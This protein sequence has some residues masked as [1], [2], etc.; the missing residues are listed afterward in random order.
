VHLDG[1]EPDGATMARAVKSLLEPVWL[2]DESMPRFAHE[3]LERLVTTT[4]AAT[5]TISINR[6]DGRGLVSLA[7]IHPELTFEGERFPLPVGRPWSGELWLAGPQQPHHRVLAQLAAERFG[8]ALENERLRD[9]DL[10]R[11]TWLT[12]LAE[13]S[14]LLAQSLDIDLTMALIPRVVVPRLGQWCAIYTARDASEL[15]LAAIAH[16]DETAVPALMT[17][18]ENA[19]PETLQRSDTYSQLTGPLDGF[20]V[21]LIARGQR[22]GVLAIGRL[23]AGRRDPDEIAVAEDIARRAALALDNARTHDE[24]RRVAQALQ[25]A[26]L[27]P[28]LPTVPD[29]GLGA[30]YVPAAEGVD[31]GGDFYDVIKMPDGRTLLLVGDVS[32]K[33]VQAATVTGLVRDVLRVLVRDGRSVPSILATLNDTLFERRERHCTLALAAV[34]P[35][36]DNGAVSVSIYLAG[37]EAPLLLRASG[38]CAPA[39]K[40][41]T[42]LGLLPKVTC[43]ETQVVLDRG[44]TLVFF[45]D[46]VTDRRK[47]DTFY[48]MEG[49]RRATARLAG[50]P[51][52]VIAAQLRLAALD[53][54]AEPARDDLCLVVL[55]NDTEHPS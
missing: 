26:L 41:G 15:K 51:A 39:G 8:L 31:V 30:E 6:A 47:G 46:G 28:V 54:S 14:E 19:G 38:E 5:A 34:S 27:P 24:R 33:G 9:T 35:P 10:R 42:A 16:A 21:P 3:L 45:T 48:G 50:Y 7:T 36:G 29:L 40:W 23:P 25:K 43:P 22:L 18:L 4:N 44:D 1:A 53:F 17:L 49:L 2:D 12:F 52:D 20:S 13:V 55:R 32:G 11:Q 37:H